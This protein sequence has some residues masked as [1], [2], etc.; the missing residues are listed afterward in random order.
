MDGDTTESRAPVDFHIQLR[1]FRL[2]LHL[3]DDADG[4]VPRDEWLVATFPMMMQVAN[5]QI[6]G[7][8]LLA[9]CT[10]L[11][12]LHHPGASCKLPTISGYK[13]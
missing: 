3:L 11:C 10:I 9:T 7:L 13:A 8:S 2:C 12:N 5:N 4:F 6:S 1:G